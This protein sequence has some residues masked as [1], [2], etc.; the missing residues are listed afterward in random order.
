MAFQFKHCCA[1]VFRV[2]LIGL[3]IGRMQ[4]MDRKYDFG[5]VWGVS[6]WW[7]GGLWRVYIYCWCDDA[8]NKLFILILKASAHLGSRTRRAWASC[9]ENDNFNVR[10]WSLLN[11]WD[12]ALWIGGERF[13]A[14]KIRG[15]IEVTGI[16]KERLT[17]QCITIIG[18]KYLPTP[19][20][21][22]Y[23]HHHH[24]HLHLRHYYHAD[25][26]N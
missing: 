23:H 10:C 17:W 13:S 3:I 26:R 11:W 7:W 1:P 20:S 2:K 21:Y 14:S 19:P 6:E 24:D 9:D 16:C 18:P 25:T 12:L 15:G 5:L 8:H 4:E 22:H